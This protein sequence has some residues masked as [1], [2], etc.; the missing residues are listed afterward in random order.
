[1][2]FICLLCVIAPLRATCS[3]V[4]RNAMQGAG[5]Y[6]SR[7]WQESELITYFRQNRQPKGEIVFSNTPEALSIL[8]DVPA[9]MSP[10][11]REYNS[12]VPTGVSKDNLFTKYSDLDGALLVWFQP[13]RAD[14]LFTLDEL[15]NSC[16]LDELKAFSDGTIYRVRNSNKRVGGGY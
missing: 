11:R 9:R 2:G 13:N 10:A 1:M 5:G 7:D 8:A 3:Q 15:K 14:F 4:N 12:A 16:D 6:N